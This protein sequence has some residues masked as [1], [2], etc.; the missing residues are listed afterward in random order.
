[1]YCEPLILT[2]RRLKRSQYYACGPNFIWHV[3]GYDKLKQFVFC[4]HGSS[5]AFSRKILWLEVASRII[6]HHL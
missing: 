5:D 6:T 3:D 4:I 1:M 2:L